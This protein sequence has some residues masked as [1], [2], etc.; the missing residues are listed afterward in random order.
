MGLHYSINGIYNEQCKNSSNFIRQYKN[1]SKQNKSEWEIMWRF[2]KLH[3]KNFFI[4][5]RQQSFVKMLKSLFYF[6][7][8]NSSFYLPDAFAQW[9]ELG[10]VNYDYESF[11][12]QAEEQILCKIYKL[13]SS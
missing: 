8:Q 3:V 4:V 1:K 10:H 9:F 6:N 13:V 5:Y 2:I 7:F 12:C 11:T